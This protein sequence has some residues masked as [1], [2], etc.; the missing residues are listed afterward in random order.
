MEEATS[1]RSR[2]FMIEDILGVPMSKDDSESA[3]EAGCGSPSCNEATQD[4]NIY[5]RS[6]QNR[7]KKPRTTFTDEQLFELERQFLRNKYLSAEERQLLADG[8]GLTDAQVKTWFQNRRMKLKRQLESMGCTAP[9]AEW[10]DERFYCGTLRASRDIRRNG[11]LPCLKDIEPLLAT[12]TRGVSR[13][14][15]SAPYRLAIPYSR[16]FG[17]HRQGV[18]WDATAPY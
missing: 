6:R 15:Y 13:L 18:V 8:L 1:D 3:N 2:G 7:T 5:E 11:S 9:G 12:S 10:R 14:H 16:Y 17:L 4:A